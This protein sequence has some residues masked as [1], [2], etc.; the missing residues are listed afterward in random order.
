MIQAMPSPEVIDQDA[1]RLPLAVLAEFIILRSCHRQ[2]EPS[3][4]VADKSAHS[5]FYTRA[6]SE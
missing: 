1:I 5:I 2:D 3:C 4:Y 6:L